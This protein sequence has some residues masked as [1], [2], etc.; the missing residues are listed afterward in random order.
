MKMAEEQRQQ[1]VLQRT[2]LVES[3]KQLADAK[4]TIEAISQKLEL[5]KKNT[6]HDEECKATA[7]NF[8]RM[9]DTNRDMVQILNKRIAT[10][11]EII[12]L[13][14]MPETGI[15]GENTREPSPPLEEQYATLASLR[16]ALES[17]QARIIEYEDEVKSWRARLVKLAENEN[18]DPILW[19]FLNKLIQ[20]RLR[21]ITPL[22]IEVRNIRED[23]ARLVLN[24]T[25]KRPIPTQEPT[26]DIKIP[27]PASQD[28]QGAP[29]PD[30]ESENVI[31][32]ERVLVVGFLSIFVFAGVGVA[33]H[34]YK[35]RRRTDR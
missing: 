33:V 11:K 32:L 30:L 23:I 3:E 17:A 20:W 5:H 19:T 26:C 21:E 34:L 10:T 9:I 2:G 16:Q 27:V 13:H 24:G 4:K 15:E 31:M 28:G 25:I 7:E 35:K 6:L 12:S 14:E 29:K 1:L 8:E 22:E 18:N